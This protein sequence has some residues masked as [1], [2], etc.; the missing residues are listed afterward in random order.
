MT[1]PASERAEATAAPLECPAPVSLRREVRFAAPLALAVMGALMPATTVIPVIRAFVSHGWPGREWVFHAF[2]A[3]NLLGACLLGPALAVRADRLGRRR[4]FAAVLAAIDAAAI[5]LVALEPRLEVMLALRFIQG[6]AGVGAVSILM[7][8]ARGRGSG[9]ATGIVGASVVFALVV[10]IPL[11]AI[12][13]KSV[14]ANALL[15]G[16]VLGAFASLAALRFVP[17]RESSGLSGRQVW[18]SAGVRLPV[19]VVALERFSV[20]AFTVTL[21]LF[22]FHV[23]QVPDGTVSRWFTIFLVAFAL[24][25]VPFTR[26]GER[27]DRRVLI[28][29]GASLYGA[30]FLVLLFLD[31]RWLPV[32]LAVGG[33]SSAAIYGPSLSMVT[34][35]VPAEARASAMGVLNAAGTLG[36]F[37]GNV[38]AGV[39]AGWLLAH[40]SSRAEAYGVVF[41]VAT[42]SQWVS[43]V[44]ALRARRVG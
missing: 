17:E 12:V 39:V 9:A 34:A 13:G 10:G 36:M 4:L 35:A 20:G 8:A 15:V 14:P 25:T 32:A 41:A 24:G 19:T 37:I 44:L 30:M 40:E 16:A 42:A 27:V 33:V 29:L 11:G 31:A 21:Q 5:A 38:V 43:V 28:A 18:R 6:A 3:A 2:M 23:L 7:G 22:G 26:L 1:V